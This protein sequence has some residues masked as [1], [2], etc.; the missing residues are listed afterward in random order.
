MNVQSLNELR[1]GEEL[2]YTG[3]GFFGFD[4]HNRSLTYVMEDEGSLCYV[5]VKY[6]GW[7]KRLHMKDIT[8]NKS[9]AA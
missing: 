3:P 2:V 6:K 4:P 8:R 1:G 9:H 5:W 7:Y